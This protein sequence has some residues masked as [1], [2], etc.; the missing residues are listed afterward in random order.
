MAMNKVEPAVIDP[1]TAEDAEIKRVF[2][3]PEGRGTGLGQ[4]ISQALIDAVSAD[5]YRRVLLD[6]NRVFTPA[7]QLY[8]KLGFR[9]CG[10]YSDIPP[11]VAAQLV[12]YELVL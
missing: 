1:L 3:S 5:G 11:D 9:P 2:V 12:F 7:R 6:T 10:P 4:H 8:E